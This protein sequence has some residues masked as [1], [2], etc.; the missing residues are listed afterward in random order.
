MRERYI[1]AAALTRERY[2]Y[3]AALMRERYIYAAALLR[4]RDHHH[5]VSLNNSRPISIRRISLVPAPIS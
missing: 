1:N 4:E 5:A 3:A 2:I